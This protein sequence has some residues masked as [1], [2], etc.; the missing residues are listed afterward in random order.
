[1]G[2]RGRSRRVR[3]ARPTGLA[4]KRPRH[5]RAGP[6][7]RSG[8]DHPRPGSGPAPGSPAAPPRPDGRVV[9][10]VLSGS[11]GRHGARPVDDADQPD[12]G[13]GQRRRAPLEFRP[14]RVARAD[15]RVRL[16]RFRRDVAGAVGVGREAPRGKRRHR[17]ARQRVLARADP[18]RRSWP[19]SPPIASRW[20][21]TQG[22]DCSRSGTTGRP[23]TTSSGSSSMP[24]KRPTRATRPRTRRADSRPSSPR[25][26]ARTR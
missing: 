24:A 18:R 14:V 16:Q 6:G 20:P 9:V 17:I 22:C 12:H 21:G 23:P 1:M 13:P 25:P 7:S 3:Q 2:D 19:R 8:G 26:A 10:R 5:V 15:P 4:A 11:A